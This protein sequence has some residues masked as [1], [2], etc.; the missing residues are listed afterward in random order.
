MFGFPQYHL[1]YSIRNGTSYPSDWIKKNLKDN[2]MISKLSLNLWSLYL[3][4]LCVSL[5]KIF[6]WSW[7]VHL[8]EL[9]KNYVANDIFKYSAEYSQSLFLISKIIY[10]IFKIRAKFVHLCEKYR[11]TKNAINVNWYWWLK[12]NEWSCC[13]WCG[14]LNW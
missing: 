9:E 8:D 10:S 3:C 6:T 13:R 14:F 11:S 4:Q 2:T 5:Y 7:W 12:C 1:C